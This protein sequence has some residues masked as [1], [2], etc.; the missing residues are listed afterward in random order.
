M[1]LIHVGLNTAEK[2]ANKQ[3][4]KWANMCVENLVAKHVDKSI[5]ERVKRWSI[6]LSRLEQ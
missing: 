2:I 5:E 1:L 4:K 6:L 3:V